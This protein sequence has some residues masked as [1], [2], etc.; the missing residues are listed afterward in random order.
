MEFLQ[1]PIN[2]GAMKIK[3]NI[4][5]AR[6]SFVKK[7]FGDEAWIKVLKILPREDQEILQGIIAN[8][9]WYPFEIGKR[10]DDAIVQVLGSG[11]HKVFEEIGVASARKNLSTVHKHFLVEGDPQAFLAKAPIIYRCYYDQGRR[12]YTPT[13]PTAGIITTYDAETFSFADCLTVIGWYKCALEM[14][15][16]RDVV[17]TEDTCRARGGDVCR[18]LVSWKTGA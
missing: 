9:V 14:C 2:K 4:L 8:I 7:H 3:G 18:Y 11:K 13:G 16:A 17:M 6:I 5:S 15:G 12:E 10:L 1:Y